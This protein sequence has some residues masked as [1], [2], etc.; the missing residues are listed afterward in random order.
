MLSNLYGVREINVFDESEVEK[1]YQKIEHSTTNLI[2]DSKD[3]Y[4]LSKIETNELRTNNLSQPIQTLYF[5]DNQLSYFHANCYAKGK[6]NG[7]LDWNTNNRFETF[8]PQ[9]AI[10]PANFDI[11]WWHYTEKTPKLNSDKKY[12]V[13]ILW[14]LMLE[15][16]T[17]EA[18]NTVV[19]NLNKFNQQ[20]STDLFLINI[21]KAFIT[22]K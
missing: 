20:D 11:E 14:T 12:K 10:N 15:K 3:F 9:S 19:Q 22:A 4:E 1:F 5:E 16:Q 8:I 7:S 17:N 2:I 6:L 13:L 18:I 21:D